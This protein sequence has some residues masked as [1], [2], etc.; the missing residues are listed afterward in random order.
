MPRRCEEDSRSDSG[1]RP[2]YPCRGG[3]G[4]S[5]GG[6]NAAGSSRALSEG[7][8]QTPDDHRH[9]SLVVDK[10][11]AVRQAFKELGVEVLPGSAAP[12]LSIILIC[13]KYEPA[14]AKQIHQTRPEQ[15]DK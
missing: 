13:L 12:E 1:W 7:R 15:L 11:E 14:E 4:G 9:L 10:K 3:S 6:S 2:A 5:L 8:T